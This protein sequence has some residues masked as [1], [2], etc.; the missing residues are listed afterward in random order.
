MGRFFPAKSRPQVGVPY[1]PS[2]GVQEAYK[3]AQPS[4]Q[5]ERQARGKR[6]KG[7]VK[8]SYQA[9]S[10]EVS[11][12]KFIAPPNYDLRLQLRRDVWEYCEHYDSIKTVADIGK[13]LEYKSK[14]KEN[15]KQSWHWL[16][17]LLD[18]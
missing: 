14:P 15:Q 10:E 16:N 6:V 2:L 11:Q 7:R 1:N 13:G 9:P 4:P 8:D 3:R 18:Y 5:P 12:S 17:P